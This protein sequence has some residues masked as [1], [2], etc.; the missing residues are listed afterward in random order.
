[1]VNLFNFNDR[2]VKKFILEFV[3]AKF[4]GSDY[5]YACI[6]KSADFSNERQVFL[7]EIEDQRFA[8]KLD[9][10]ADK[11]GRLKDEYEILSNLQSH[12]APH[13]RVAIV[14]PVYFS[15]SCK[16]F[17]TE[18]VGRKTATEAIRGIVEDNQAAQ[19]YR[20]AGE[21]L[22]VLHSFR[23]P[24][25]E[26][27]WYQWMLE[28]LNS[29]ISSLDVQALADEYEPL[30]QKM[31]EAS[32]KFNSVR[33]LK[34]FSNGDFHGAN[35][36]I[37]KGCVYGLDFTEAKEKLA[38]Y[39]IVDFLKVDVYRDGRPADVDRS[40]ILQHNKHMFFKL[41][42]HPINFDVLDFCI[43]GRLLIDWLSITRQRYAKSS[44][45]RTKF[46]KFRERLLMAFEKQI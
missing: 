21:W 27:F 22:N 39:D 26:R 12:F 6:Y 28:D 7:V 19:I 15:P 9:L 46:K 33:D 4:P 36:I 30:I 31:H 29:I 42:K 35:L 8:L 23:R 45:Q 40:G 3:H 16:F 38:V 10:T 41:Y 13:G 37:D 20:R 43:R 32:N 18:H 24:T 2:L 11:T 14:K 17:V 44:F 34:V 25:Y 5:V 1:M